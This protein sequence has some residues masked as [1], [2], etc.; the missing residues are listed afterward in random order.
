MTAVYGFALLVV[1]SVWFGLSVAF[2]FRPKK[3]TALKTH[4]HF[5]LVPLWT[6][7][8]PRPGTS[9]THLLFRDRVLDI[10]I[11]PWREV[12]AMK[13]SP[14]RGFWNPQ[15]RVGK[16]LHDLEY[17]L[18]Q[19]QGAKLRREEILLSMA[20]LVLINYIAGLP[21]ANFSTSTQFAVVRSWGYRG[22]DEPD[23]MFLSEFH[24]VN[25]AAD[26]VGQSIP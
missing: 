26:F 7:F 8:A 6:F 17:H 4:D 14:L 1:L 22:G 12:L 10:G 13:R 21:R 18:L 3:L 19:L 16:T 23:I 24:S 11:T 20:Y 15:K 9:D 2:Q 5:S 25:D